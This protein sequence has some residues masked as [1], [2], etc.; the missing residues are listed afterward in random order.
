MDKLTK[1]PRFDVQVVAASALA[2]LFVLPGKQTVFAD[3]GKKVGDASLIP[4][5]EVAK[6]NKKEDLWVVIRGEVRERTGCCQ[7]TTD[8]T[9]G[10]RVY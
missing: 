9:H 8:V 2:L 7:W 3:E 10:E 1:R 5:S 4:F 6:H